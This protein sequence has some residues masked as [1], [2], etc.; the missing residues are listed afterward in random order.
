MRNHRRLQEMTWQEERKTE[1]WKDE[2]AKIRLAHQTKMERGPERQWPKKAKFRYADVEE[3]AQVWKARVAFQNDDVVATYFH[4]MDLCYHG[5]PP[6]TDIGDFRSFTP[7]YSEDRYRR[8]V[9]CFLKY[10]AKMAHVEMRFLDTGS[11]VLRREGSAG[12][13]R[14]KLDRDHIYLGSMERFAD[15]FIR[16]T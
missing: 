13:R 8:L 9:Y 1:E 10:G 14:L 7:C 4:L 2:P 15:H 16:F 12:V 11:Y 3:G 6:L 5:T